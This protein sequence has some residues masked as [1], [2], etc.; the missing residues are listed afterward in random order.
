MK[1][2][3]LIVVPLPPPHHGSNV[4]NQQVVTCRELSEKYEVKVLPLHYVASIAD[5]GTV[6]TK[7]MILLIGYLIKLFMRLVTFRPDVV[8]FVPAVTGF[9]FYRD[10]LFVLLFKTFGV[11]LVCHLHG[12][13]IK[14][15]LDLTLPRLIYRWF[16]NGATVVHLSPLLYDDIEKVVSYGQCRFIPNGIKDVCLNLSGEKSTYQVAKEPVILFISNLF[17]SKGPLVLLD[18]CRI[19]KN[20][21]LKFKTY[22]VGN[23]SAEL[24]K[25]MFM[26]S[27][28]RSG[29][30]GCVEYL[31]SRYGGDKD[32]ILL[33]SDVLAFPTF[34]EKEAFPLVLLEAMA[35]GLPVVS[36]REGSIPVI[37]DDG[38]TGFVIDKQNSAQLAEKIEFLISN[39]EQRQ[40]MGL[41]GRAKFE[42]CY[43]LEKFYEN[44]LLMFDEVFETL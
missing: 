27:I 36:T 28:D 7:K 15:K 25:K 24:T 20:K 39:H 44:L 34:Y 1:K 38:I 26:E 23:P 21:G 33:K 14:Q 30:R 9:S 16:F 31:G 19:L 42:Q 29:L 12:K 10:C 22:I 32:E 4:M 41:A 8:Y 18:A 11:H 3:L 5:I 40:K 35:A 17:L 2:K 6:N 43:T 13:G 37:I